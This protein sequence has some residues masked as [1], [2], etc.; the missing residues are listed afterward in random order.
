MLRARDDEKV[1]IEQPLERQVAAASLNVLASYP[2]ING[3]N[4]ARPA[5]SNTR[6]HVKIGHQPTVALGTGHLERNATSGN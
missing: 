5:S 4:C 6:P 2:E 1:I 3:S